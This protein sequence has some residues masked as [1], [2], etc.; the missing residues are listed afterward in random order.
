MVARNAE[1]LRQVDLEDGEDRAEVD[2]A[3]KRRQLELMAKY[4]DDAEQ[5]E[6]ELF[7][8]ADEQQQWDC[9]TILSTYTNTDNHPGVIKTER[10]VRPSE[11]MKIEL[12]KQFKVP[13]DGLG[14]VVAEVVSKDKQKLKEAKPYIEQSV[15]E[16]PLTGDKKE[17]KKAVKAENREKR[18]LKKELKLAFAGQKQ[19]N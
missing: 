12:H 14:P 2:A 19:R 1:A 5:D 4:E 10:R 18:K 9:E 11:R 6:S 3:I 13:V 8:V 7:P 15:P 17:L 16:T